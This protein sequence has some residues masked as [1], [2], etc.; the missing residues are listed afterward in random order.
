MKVTF[1]EDDFI[2]GF[3][4]NKIEEF[5]DEMKSIK[6]LNKIENKENSTE[7]RIFLIE[8]LNTLAGLLNESIEKDVT[9]NLIFALVKTIE[10]FKEIE[11]I[12]SSKE[13]MN[14]MLTHFYSINLK[15]NK[16]CKMNEPSIK[17]E[18]DLIIVYDASVN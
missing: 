2:Y 1:N 11:E 7:Q 12:S 18:G 13:E 15:N 9:Y 4:L 10:K 17:A 8:S 16:I 6:R 5:I 14:K 3:S